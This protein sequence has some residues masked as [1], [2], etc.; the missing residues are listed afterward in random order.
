MRAFYVS[1]FLLMV[2]NSCRWSCSYVWT[3]NK[4]MNKVVYDT[5]WYGIWQRFVIYTKVLKKSKDEKKLNFPKS[6]FPT[7]FSQ[8]GFKKFYE[9]DLCLIMRSGWERII[10]NLN[11]CIYFMYLWKQWYLSTFVL[12]ALVMSLQTDVFSQWFDERKKKMWFN[13]LWS[14]NSKHFR[15]CTCDSI[16]FF[17]FANKDTG[18]NKILILSCL[19]NAYHSAYYLLVTTLFPAV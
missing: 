7:G 5:L 4:H 15:F 8:K 14:F 17:L 3:I 9:H 18:E 1:A 19:F 6:S 11:C 12:C 10:E 2:I 13:Y 16:F